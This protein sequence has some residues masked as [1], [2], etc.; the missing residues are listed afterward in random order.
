MVLEDTI[1][2]ALSGGNISTVGFPIAAFTVAFFILAFLVRDCTKRNAICQSSKDAH[3]TAFFKQNAD[4][5]E[6]HTEAIRDITN[7]LKN[8]TAE[9]KGISVK[10]ETYAKIIEKQMDISRKK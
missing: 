3:I 10:V 7:E 1:A 2:T 9:L 8:I 4:S 6:K 5:Q